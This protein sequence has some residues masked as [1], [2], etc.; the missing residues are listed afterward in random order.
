MN[1]E[2][3]SPDVTPEPAPSNIG[4]IEWVDLTVDDAEHIKSFYC[5]VVGWKS[6]DVEM[7]TY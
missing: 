6:T 1:E 3:D 7:G 4:R 5:N 2:T